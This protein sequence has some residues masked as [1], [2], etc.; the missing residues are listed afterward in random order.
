MIQLDSLTKQFTNFYFI[1]PSRVTDGEIYLVSEVSK[2][3]AILKTG[4]KYDLEK[5]LRDIR[6]PAGS[7]IQGGYI[8]EKLS[9]RAL[10]GGGRDTCR[11]GFWKT[12]THKRWSF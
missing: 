2:V 5:I 9:S 8:K 11:A 4:I 7:G 1:D 6:H 12:G 10:L 3:T